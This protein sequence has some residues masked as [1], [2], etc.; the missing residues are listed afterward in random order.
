MCFERQPVW[1]NV[2]DLKAFVR[3]QEASNYHVLDKNCH[4]FAY[5]CLRTLAGP[6]FQ[7][8]HPSFGPFAQH[9]QS[10]FVD[11]LRQEREGCASD[12]APPR[13]A[14]VIEAQADG[15]PGP[16]RQAPA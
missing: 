4:R 5:D 16:Q 11:L 10:R 7:N 12:P 13:G 15:S 9:C 3:E 14:L 6:D 8:E 1:I 2:G